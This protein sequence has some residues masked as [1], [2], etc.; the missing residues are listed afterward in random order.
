MIWVN[1]SAQGFPAH[2]LKD[3]CEL[4]CRSLG[5]KPLIPT[6]PKQEE[7]DH[8]ADRS[9]GALGGEGGV[10][11]TLTFGARLE[12]SAQPGTRRRPKVI[13]NSPPN[14]PAGT[15]QAVPLP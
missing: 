2:V 10:F 7:F 14:L 8:G 6:P 3:V 5:R 15:E 11:V 13:W 4:Y 12:V 1:C 9:R